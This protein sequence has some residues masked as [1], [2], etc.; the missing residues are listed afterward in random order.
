MAISQMSTNARGWL[1]MRFSA[2]IVTNQLVFGATPLRECWFEKLAREEPA[3]YGELA[4]GIRIHIG[5]LLS[6]KYHRQRTFHHG[7][8]TH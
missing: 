8:M 6:G 1:N 4:P 2:K 5:T 3:L 7:N